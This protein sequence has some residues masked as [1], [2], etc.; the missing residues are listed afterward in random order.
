MTK[1]KQEKERSRDGG[2][3]GR[4]SPARKG[5]EAESAIRARLGIPADA[6]KVLV[7]GE[8]SHWD[9]NWIM[10]SEEYFRLRVRRILDA[11]VRELEADP[12]RV[13]SV[14]CVFFLRMYWERRPAKRD[15]I[16]RLVNEGRV[17]LT[18][19][20]MTTPLAPIMSPCP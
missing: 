18:G 8:S 2:T 16:R 6:E 5:E 15:A 3:P 9:P 13:F 7:L 4:G 20:G 1:T 10:T 12:R 19:S 11:A 14:E 17:R